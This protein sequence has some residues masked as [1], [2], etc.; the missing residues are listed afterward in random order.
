M[1]YG[2]DGVWIAFPIADFSST[3]VTWLYLKREI[4][5]RLNPL[6]QIQSAYS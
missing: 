5:Q 6:I 1:F 4:N 2:L 3:V